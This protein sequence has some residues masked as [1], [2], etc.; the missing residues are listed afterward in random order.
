MLKEYREKKG[1]TQEQLA[2]EINVST[3]TIQNIERTNKTYVNIAIKIS[4]VLG[5]TVEEIFE[6]K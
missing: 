3:R 2:R 1:I 5:Y 4:K 6:E